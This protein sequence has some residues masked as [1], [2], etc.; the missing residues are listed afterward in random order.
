MSAQI[1]RFWGVFPQTEKIEKTVKIHCHLCGTEVEYTELELSKRGL[2]YKVCPDCG[3]S[4]WGA[5]Q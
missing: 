1:A 4:D 2:G 3:R 5:T